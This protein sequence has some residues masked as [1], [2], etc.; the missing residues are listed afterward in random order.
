MPTPA[1]HLDQAHRNRALLLQLLES[2]VADATSRQWTVTI[3]FYC[4][5]HCLEAHI[6]AM[7][8]ASRDH[9][10]RERML[11]IGPAQIPASQYVRYRFVKQMSI[12]A[13]YRLSSFSDRY[14]QRE[15]LPRL[16][17]IARLGRSAAALTRSGVECPDPT[18]VGTFGWARDQQSVTE[19]AAQRIASALA[20]EA[21]PPG[22]LSGAATKRQV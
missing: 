19:T 2:Q 8:L 20:G 6:T 5:V 9:V 21:T 22:R 17:E 7:G 13:R 3:A 4:A 10:S 14:I 18:E 1:E 16:D 15:I 11:M 12:N